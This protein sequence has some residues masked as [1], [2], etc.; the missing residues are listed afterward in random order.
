MALNTF[1]CNHLM[2]LH[3][4]GLTHRQYLVVFILHSYTQSHFK[5]PF[6]MSLQEKLSILLNWPFIK[7]K[8]LP[9][10]TKPIVLKN[11]MQSIILYWIALH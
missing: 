11:W 8:C 9:A 10:D 7:A 6:S 2:P 5:W 3:F 4:K 1:K